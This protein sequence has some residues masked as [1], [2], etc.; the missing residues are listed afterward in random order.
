MERH[1][2]ADLFLH[3]GDG[4]YELGELARRYPAAVF[5][6]VRGNC[7]SVPQSPPELLVPVA[8]KK[9]FITHGHSYGVKN[10]LA[11]LLKRARLLGAEVCCY[12]H[13]HTASVTTRDGVLLLNPGSVARPRQERASYAIVDLTGAGIAAHIVKM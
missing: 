7:D 5:R 3:L 13:T 1:P 2:E 9:F 8:D 10:S 6:V 11:P 12:G 4:E